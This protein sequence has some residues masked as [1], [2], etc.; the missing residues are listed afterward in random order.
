MEK[1]VS[2]PASGWLDDV[3]LALVITRREMRDQF[4]D[5]RII[6]PMVV[7]TLI[8]PW[9]M[10]FTASQAV[11]FV[12]RYNAPEIG[13][14][15]IPFLLMVVGFFPISVSLVIALESFVGEKERRSIEPLLCSPLSDGRYILA[16]CWRQWCR[17]CSPATWASRCT[18]QGF[19]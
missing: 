2:L 13:A 18:W 6:F 15:L 4:R 1:K 14:R 11:R 12:E 10:D 16:N 9:L 17:R 8:F 5:W 7:L 3:R 19:T